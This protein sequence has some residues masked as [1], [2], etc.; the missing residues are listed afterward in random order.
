MKLPGFLPRRRINRVLLL[1][2]LLFFCLVG[3]VL[4][5]LG[6]QGVR[7]V[8]NSFS[9]GQVHIGQASGTFLNSFT[10]A[11]I[12]VKGAGK[13]TTLKKFLMRWSPLALLR[14]KL[15]LEQVEVD[16]LFV[17][18]SVSGPE[19]EPAKSSFQP[20]K[21]LS[22]FS[23]QVDDFSASDVAFDRGFDRDGDPCTSFL[24][25]SIHLAFSGGLHGVRIKTLKVDGPDMALDMKGSLVPGTL[26]AAGGKRADWQVDFGGLFRFAGFGFHS[27]TGT[28]H[29]SGDAENPDLAAVLFTPG[30]LGVDMKLHD[31]TTDPHWTGRL[32]G[33]DFDLSA[34]IKHC[35][36]I[37]FSDVDGDVKGDFQHYEGH[38]IFTG[39]WEHRK[40]LR[41]EG[42]VNGNARKIDINDVRLQ[43]GESL[44]TAESI[45]LY[46]KEGFAWRG[47]LHGEKIDPQLIVSQLG[48]RLDGRF[49][50]RLKTSGKILNHVVEGEVNIA[51]LDGDINNQPVWLNGDIQLDNDSVSSDKL[52]LRSGER[53]GEAVVGP[54]RFTWEG[55]GGWQA[56]ILLKKFN[57]GCFS[58]LFEGR[59]DGELE[60]S[61][62]LASS[63]DKRAD[64]DYRSLQAELR[65]TELSGTIRGNKLSGSGGISFA[66]GVLLTDGFSLTL[67]RSQL[68]LSRGNVAT[69]SESGKLRVK[70]SFSSPDI[71][72]FLVRSRGSLQVSLS[73]EGTLSRPEM[74]A[75]FSGRGMA[76]DQFSL[77]SV[78]GSIRLDGIENGLVSG[79]LH[80]MK[81]KNG[82]TRIGALDADLAGRLDRHTLSVRLSKGDFGGG[83]VS[84]SLS[85][86]GG[87]NL[88]EKRWKGV[89]GGGRL[90]LL[91][92]KVL[93]LVQQGEARLSLGREG[94]FLKSF[95]LTGVP[96]NVCINGE[97][98][99]ARWQTSLDIA[100][101]DP[102]VLIKGSSPLLLTGI[103]S[104][105]A[106]FSGTGSVPQSGTFTLNLPLAK[107]KLE[108]GAAD[109]ETLVLKK[110]RFNGSLIA[111]TL[112][113]VGDSNVGG[114]GLF[115]F[116]LY[117]D[118]INGIGDLPKLDTLPLSG[119]LSLSNL[120]VDMLGALL[121]AGQPEGRLY[122][123]F[124]LSG[125]A[126]NPILKGKARLDGSVGV[127]SRGITLTNVGFF[128]SADRNGM[129]V[130]GSARSGKGQ[131][132][133]GGS[134]KYLPDFSGMLAITGKDFTA[135]SEPE[136]TFVVNPDL[137]FQFNE[138]GGRLS[139]KVA[140]S[141]GEVDLDR[142]TPSVSASE[143]VVLVKENGA[144]ETDWP[145]S[146]DVDVALQDAVKVKG[147]GL[148]GVLGGN[149]VVR[150]EPEEVFTGKGLLQLKKAKVSMYG[151]TLDIKRGNITF[152]GGPIDNP[153]ID[154]RAQKTVTNEQTLSEGYTVGID[155]NGLVQSLQYHLF[156]SPVMTETEILSYLVLGHSLAGAESGDESLLATVAG[157]LGLRGGSVLFGDLGSIFSIDDVH[158]E[159]SATKENISLVVGK[160]LSRDVYVGY[161]VNMFSRVGEF[162]IRYSMKHGFSVETH[163]SSE[164]T[165]A[166]LLFTFER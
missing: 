113:L 139:G 151:R 140:V 80:A 46:W 142:F 14:G 3:A 44:V 24:F 141:S 47:D 55:D 25:D 138:K 143:D 92:E 165:G 64:S 99:G 158:M 108:G 2:L 109:G 105:T 117:T 45:W 6:V 42:D 26:P 87:Y 81:L 48:G 159:G 156:S 145:V 79:T 78:N 29:L 65:L 96:G 58:P 21:L 35:P 91:Q 149:L 160:R 13:P 23:V 111:G 152:A 27:M 102:G 74:R 115:N 49:D 127:L 68:H 107:F 76:R 67:G 62:Q 132:K 7:L 135:V 88:A 119:T 40:N 126:R 66:D 84:S 59:V 34:W 72:D 53:D 164:S 89:L 137:I 82:S 123:D 95:C 1:L 118:G 5:P 85:V 19:E 33:Y 57:P 93:R 120:K 56:K 154:V 131:V 17:D 97:L 37:V 15:H 77:G 51:E 124:A 16:G 12:S 144:K 146:L 22:L 134:L 18:G 147:Y 50:T 61:G 101:V 54:A 125:T 86:K 43:R 136:Y 129:R 8:A 133:V 31:L 73:A 122:A 121:P 157:K 90:E 128:V 60:S 71:G 150:R 11:D 148:S 4:S 153:G 162:W 70:G 106:Q 100:K 103:L 30:T 94:G 163:S 75:E 38:A 41:L 20:Q 32:C 39:D 36:A 63:S 69:D 110:T 161:D 10:F 112:R 83:S 104:G 114:N 130:D 98:A 155:V 52:L 28:L 166:D 116:D 9:G